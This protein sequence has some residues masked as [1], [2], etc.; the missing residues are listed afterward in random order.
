M[1][2]ALSQAA[3]DAVPIDRAF[4]APGDAKGG[5]HLLMALQKMGPALPTI[6]GNLQRAQ[7]AGAKANPDALS[8]GQ[9]SLLSEA[10]Q[11]IDVNLNRVRE[12]T[13]LVP[14]LVDILG[15]NG[16]RT[17]II[18]QVNPS[19]L[20]SGGG[21]IGTVSV[22]TADAG[23]L[24]LT[25]SG[26]V[27]VFD[28]N[29]GR[30][31]TVGYR[32]PPNQPNYVAPPGPLIG[33][34]G[35]QSWSFPD[36]N[37]FP[38]FKTNAKWAA[39]FAQQRRGINADGVIGL[40]YYA[41]ESLLDVT[42][43]LPLSEFGVTLDSRNFV[44]EVLGRDLT[45]NPTHKSILAAAAAQLIQKISELPSERWPSLVSTMNAAVVHRHLQVVFSR[46]FDQKQLN[47]FGW[48][49]TMN[50]LAFTDFLY[51]TEDNMGGTKAN[52]FLSRQYSVTLTKRGTNLHHTVV[53]DLDENPD[54]RLTGAYPIDHYNAYLRFYTG[55]HARNVTLTKVSPSNIAQIPSAYPDTEVPTGYIVADGWIFITVKPGVASSHMQ[56]RFDFDTQW[57][58][59]PAGMH[60]IYWQKQPGT[61]D[62]PITITWV[63]DGK[64]FHVAGDLAQDRI[65]T[66]GPKG[67]AIG[68]GQEPKAQLPGLQF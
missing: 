62:D 66:L 10:R 46:D 7:Q 18:E 48:K 32:P 15:G 25:F 3:I 61:A 28:L 13:S 65:L 40:D 60:R 22:L 45:D 44:K 5:Q 64:P 51:E 42:G 36:S 54:T 52:F 50:P 6:L 41:V 39:F 55:D 9:R 63:A 17:Y 14:A 8:P 35:G 16:Q 11:S 29:H 59:D 68:N 67:V 24:K 33:F 58:S 20:R 1:G 38:D 21:F 43:P 27:S 49:P 4:V 2:T 56:L 30:V 37:F 26:D 53:V 23:A 12:L 19:E 34:Y 31:P 47:N 57:T